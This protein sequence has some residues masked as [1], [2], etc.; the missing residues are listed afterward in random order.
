[1]DRLSGGNDHRQAASKPVDPAFAL[2]AAA[3]VWLEGVDLAAVLAR[4]GLVT[5]GV[6]VLMVMVL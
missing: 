1:M 5:V 6:G 4:A 2:I 3:A